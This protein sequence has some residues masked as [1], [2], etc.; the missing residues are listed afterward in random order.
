MPYLS[1]LQLRF[2]DFPEHAGAG[3]PPLLPDG[4]RRSVSM[5]AIS[6]YAFSIPADRFNPRLRFLIGLM[7]SA[8]VLSAPATPRLSPTLQIFPRLQ[9]IAS[10]MPDQPFLSVPAFPV[11]DQ[12]RPASSNTFDPRLRCNAPP[13]LACYS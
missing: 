7:L 5:P 4:Q 9:L 3:L 10:S 13:R 8:L 6:S 12:Q 2:L 1:Q 11:P